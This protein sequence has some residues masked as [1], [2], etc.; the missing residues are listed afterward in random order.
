MGRAL[1]LT[2]VI[3]AGPV[4]TVWADIRPVMQA[5]V[6]GEIKVIIW[7]TCTFSNTFWAVLWM[8]LCG[9]SGA[10]YG[11]CSTYVIKRVELRAFYAFR[12]CG[13]DIENCT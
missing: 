9:I 6:L 2:V 5:E 7:R 4:G 13:T 10:A 12:L 3:H 1:P 8:N 11:R